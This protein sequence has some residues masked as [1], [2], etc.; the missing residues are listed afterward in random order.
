MPLDARG[1]GRRHTMHEV[2]LDGLF[3]IGA[4][5]HRGHPGE[6]RGRIAQKIQGEYEYFSS[7]LS[8]EDLERIEAYS[9]LLSQIDGFQERDSFGYGLRLGVMLM[10]EVFYAGD[11][12]PAEW[13]SKK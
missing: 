5:G 10:C 12:T 9:D 3:G 11:S 8:V 2:I 7:L 13:S 4:A 1:E 6:E